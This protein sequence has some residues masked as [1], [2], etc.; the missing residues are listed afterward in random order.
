MTQELADSSQKEDAIR[1]TRT[2]A[3]K[4]FAEIA[5]RIVA[6]GADMIVIL[7]AMIFLSDHVFSVIDL[8]EELHKP[9]WVLLLI[10]YFILSWTSRLRATPSQFLLGMRVLHE[11]GRPLSMREATIRS[12]ALVALWGFALFALKQFFGPGVWL[13]IAAVAL[14]L[15]VPSITARRQGPHDFLAHSVVVNRRAMRAA[16]GEKRMHEFLANRERA[17]S[18]AARPSIHKMAVDAIALA[19]PLFVMVTVFQVGHQK[20]MQGR[21]FYATT[22]TQEMKHMAMAWFET[23]GEWP[24]DEA[25]LG[26]PLRHNYPAGGYFELQEDGVIRIQF[27][28]LPE[29][30]DGSILL[31]P[32]VRDGE[33]TWQCRAVGDFERP[34]LP[35]SCRDTI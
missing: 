23:N 24:R 28:I 5:V 1:A 12:V 9:I 11:T 10:A 20:N 30:K 13:K 17:V 15:Y 4:L 22:E 27:E 21:V 26:R 34:Y 35:A 31:E 3:R 16:D 18:K 33:V 7:F 14:L 2:Y 6:Y 32:R 29:F 19:V 25:E 8:S